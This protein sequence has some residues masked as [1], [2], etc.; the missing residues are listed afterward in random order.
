MNT[1]FTN[2]T[3]SPFTDVKNNAEEAMDKINNTYSQFTD[4]KN[5]AEEAMDKI[6]NTYSPFTDAK[7]NDIYTAFMATKHHSNE[8]KKN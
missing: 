7:N 1:F 5:N 8:Y 6:N 4:A 3:Y 2:N